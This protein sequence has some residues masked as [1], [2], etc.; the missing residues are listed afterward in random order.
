[1]LA[2]CDPVSVNELL[3]NADDYLDR[4]ERRRSAT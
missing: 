3:G 1:M 2:A 4:M